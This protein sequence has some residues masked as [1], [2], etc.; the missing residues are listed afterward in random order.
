[1]AHGGSELG[2]ERGERRPDLF[3]VIRQIGLEAHDLSGRGMLES[4]QPG[5]QC[6][7]RKPVDDLSD[8]RRQLVGLGPEGHAVVA[9]ADQRMTDMGHVN[10]DLV[11]AAGFQP[12]LD[13]AGEGRGVARLAIAFGHRVMGDGMSDVVA[14]VGAHGAFQAV[15]RTAERGVDGRVE[16]IGPAPDNGLVGPFEIAGAAVIGELVGVPEADR[17]SFQPL[18]RAAVAAI[19]PGTDATSMRAAT[20]AMDQARAYFL[21]LVAER[22]KA[23]GDDLL[24]GL[25]AAREAGDALSDDEVV[26]TAVLL[27][28][29]G[30]ETTTNLI[31]N[32]LLAVAPPSGFQLFVLVSILISIA[33]VPVALTRSDSP[34]PLET[35]KLDI[36]Q[37]YRVS[38]VGAVGAAAAGLANAAFWGM[39]PVYVQEIGYG[40]AMIAAFMS[41]AIIGAGLFQFPMGSL[42]DKVD[43]RFVIV[44]SSL[45]GAGASALL[46]SFAGLSQNALLG[47]SFLFGAFIIPVFGICAA[48]ANDHSALGKAVATSGG[49]LLL[50]GVGSVIG[51]LV[52]ALVMSAFHPAALF[53]YISGVYLVLAVFSLLRIGINRP[54][55]VGKKTRFIP[56]AK[57]PLT[58]V[59]RKRAKPQ[60]KA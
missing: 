52:G 38:P 31:G 46:A 51:A 15:A 29:A 11:G 1:M 24:S 9:V 14:I 41:A 60:P 55:I 59:Y 8:V 53:W 23:P 13:E 16:G 28:S 54:S 5:M 50:Y 39:A 47:F 45:L 33:L 18:I 6:L 30:F 40:S 21:D 19:D 20:T 49:L 27:F 58:R 32:G 42:S 7:S 34:A 43:R 26:S 56:M 35:A 4:E 57:S 25:I 2:S 44:G 17:A 3:H 36:V 10:A 37:L 48:H 12:A 22:R